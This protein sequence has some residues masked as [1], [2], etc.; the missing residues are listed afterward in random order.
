MHHGKRLGK[1]AS[2][3]RIVDPQTGN[4]PVRIAVDNADQRLAIGQTTAV[5]IVVGAHKQA[6]VVPSTALVDLGEGPIV[7]VVREGK[8]IQLHPTAVATHGTRTIVSGTDLHSGEPVVIDGGFNL[9]DETPVV[10][11]SAKPPATAE[12]RP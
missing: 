12:H 3:G 2:V 6:L 10:S 5:S 1:V 4:L 9:P 11:E 8:A 7:V